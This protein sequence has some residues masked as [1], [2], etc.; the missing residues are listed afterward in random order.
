MKAG[1]RLLSSVLPVLI[2]ISAV[3]PFLTVVK[4]NAA[5]IVSPGDVNDDNSISVSDAFAALRFSAGIEIPNETQKEMADIDFDGQITTA[6][7]QKILRVAAGIEPARQFK[8]GDWKVLTP[9]TCKEEG[10]EICFCEEYGVTRTR[11]IPL[12]PHNFK[13]YKCTYCGTDIYKTAEFSIKDTTLRFGDDY[14]TI[15]SKIGKPVK[16]YS[17]RVPDSSLWIKYLLFHNEYKDFT[18]IACHPTE[19]IISLY[20]FDKSV[21]ISF[22]DGSKYVFDEISNKTVKDN[23][24]FTVFYDKELETPV[25]YACYYMAGSRSVNNTHDNSATNSISMLLIELVNATRVAHGGYHLYYQS[26]VER[27]ALAHSRDMAENNYFA[28]VN[29]SGH[30]VLDRL[31]KAGISFSHCGENILASTHTNPFIMHDAW[32]NSPGHR[33][34]MLNRVY[35]EIGIGFHISTTNSAYDIYVTQNYIRPK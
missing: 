24:Y 16:T 7:A 13:G 35:T 8:F 2:I 31:L 26:E 18:V 32:Y 15:I 25:P 10:V 27:V 22:L 9:A 14:N 1:K 28:H 17:E 23:V 34:V 4:V 21:S 29:A 6:D 3:L 30:N 11:S 20:T 5:S 19:G 12:T 33:K